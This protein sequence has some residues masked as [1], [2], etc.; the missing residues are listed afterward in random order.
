V[1]RGST[2]ITKGSKIESKFCPVML[3]L[4][5]NKAHIGR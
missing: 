3:V 1:L 5:H 2:A 4:E